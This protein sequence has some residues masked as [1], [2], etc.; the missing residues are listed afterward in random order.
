MR[1]AATIHRIRPDADAAPR[2]L[3]SA[4][5]Q[6]SFAPFLGV[7]LVAI[8]I[9]ACREPTPRIVVVARAVE[10]ATLR[11]KVTPGLFTLENRD[12]N[13]VCVSRNETREFRV[14]SSA[15]RMLFSLGR[16]RD[17]DPLPIRFR[18]RAEFPD[19]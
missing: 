9:A 15:R 18:I 2:V 10:P 6:T 1:F 14:D 3:S 13:A 17:A 12:R 5:M 7:L 4:A 8:G 19:G 16:F 11:A